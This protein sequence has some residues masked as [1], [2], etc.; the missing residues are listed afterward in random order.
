MKKNDKIEAD[1]NFQNKHLH[2]D[3]IS[4]SILPQVID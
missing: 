1:I 2:L 4:N 3:Q